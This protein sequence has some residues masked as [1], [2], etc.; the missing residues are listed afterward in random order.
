MAP[1]MDLT[2]HKYNMLTVIEVDTSKK[3]GKVFWHCLCDCGNKTSVVAVALRE[4][5]TKSC[6]CLGRAKDITGKIYG[7]WT[8][9]ESVMIDGKPSQRYTCKCLCGTVKTVRR[10]E[11]ISGL[12]RSCGCAVKLPDGIAARN[13]LLLVYKASARRRG[14]TW[15]LTDEA[16]IEIIT[17]E[18]H[19]CSEPPSQQMKT[20]TSLYI[21]NGIDRVNNDVGY[22]IGN[23]VSCC[24]ICNMAKH[25]LDRQVFMDWIKRVYM[26]SVWEEPIEYDTARKWALNED[27][28]WVELT[29]E[30]IDTD[31][32][33]YLESG[34]HFVMETMQ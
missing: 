25:V 33:N 16:F 20:S 17:K 19:Y 27:D 5:N 1:R 21:Y 23:V 14:H 7:K 15:G 8:V 12:S 2:G 28:E 11:L 31:M 13:S 3:T 9:L 32:P 10:R 29:G 6:G 24:K 26:T 22:E 34:A 4:G 18:C 30:W